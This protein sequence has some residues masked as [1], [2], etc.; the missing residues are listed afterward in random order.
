MHVSYYGFIGQLSLSNYK[1]IEVKK[2]YFL[3]QSLRRRKKFRYSWRVCEY[4][5]SDEYYSLSYL[6]VFEFTNYSYSYSY[7]SWLRK[8]I[9]I[10]GKNNY[11]LITE[12]IS[13]LQSHLEAV[14]G[15]T[16]HQHVHCLQDTVFWDFL[17][18]SRSCWYITTACPGS[19][20]TCERWQR[21]V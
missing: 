20:G 6:Q 1:Y 4:F 9:P 10:R 8:S 2:I 7:R 18:R 11:L 21:L 19:Y 14:P 5:P 12:V 3:K 16:H 13:I 17:A 15:Q